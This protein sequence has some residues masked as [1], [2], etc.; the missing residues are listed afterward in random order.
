MINTPVL[1]G[2]HVQ[3]K[4]QLCVC[5]CGGGNMFIKQKERKACQLGM[6]CNPFIVI[7]TVVAD[8]SKRS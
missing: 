3:C 7:L 6:Q 1:Y 8:N 5:V 2:V 4:C